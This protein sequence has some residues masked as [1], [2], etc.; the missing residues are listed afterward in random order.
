VQGATV[1]PYKGGGNLDVARVWNHDWRMR[2]LVDFET[3]ESSQV[4]FELPSLTVTAGAADQDATGHF[5][6][7]GSPSTNN[8]TGNFDGGMEVVPPGSAVTGLVA[9]VTAE[10]RRRYRV[11]LHARRVSDSTATASPRARLHFDRGALGETLGD[12]LEMPFITATEDGYERYEID[13]SGVESP[14]GTVGV[15]VEISLGA[16]GEFDAF[17]DILLFESVPPCFDDCDD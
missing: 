12:W 4:Q 16:D 10:P 9:S 5:A 1:F 13:A 11:A 17:D 3:P 8:F 6:N 2:Y 15:S 14:A 7:Y